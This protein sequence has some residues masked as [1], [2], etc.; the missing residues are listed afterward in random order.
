MPA[1]VTVT[2]LMAAT[3]FMETASAWPAGRVSTE[4]SWPQA[5]QSW[6]MDPTGG[7][8][9]RAPA[10][11]SGAP[12]R[13]TLP[14]S[15]TGARCHLPCPDG[16]WG[17]NCS[18]SCTCRNGGT[19]VPENGNCVC[20][21]G[22]R[23]PSCQKCE[24]PS[25]SLLRQQEGAGPRQMPEA[26]HC[27]SWRLLQCREGREPVGSRADPGVVPA[28]SHH[29]PFPPSLPARPL[30]QALCALQVCQPLLLPPLGRDVLLPGRLDRPQLLPA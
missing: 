17:A 18:K 19:C 12:A 29:R 16:F 1:A 30:W 26:P 24:A 4:V 22:F 3:L 7:M 10:D 2:T 14:F 23:G 6:G 9:A 28:P 8:S 11:V 15:P 5:P 13:L 20:A 25:P 21:P 27:P